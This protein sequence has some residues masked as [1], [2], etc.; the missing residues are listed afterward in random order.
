MCIIVCMYI[1]HIHTCMYIENYMYM[2]E[3]LGRNWNKKELETGGERKQRE[4]EE[5]MY[6]YNIHVTCNM[7][8]LGVRG[9]GRVR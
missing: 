7:C 5:N 3:E 6:M 9:G 4:E 2:Y 8:L 1:V